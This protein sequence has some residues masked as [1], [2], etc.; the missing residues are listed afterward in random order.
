MMKKL[1]FILWVFLLACSCTTTNKKEDAYNV[2]SPL[3]VTNQ[4]RTI[5]VHTEGDYFNHIEDYLR[6]TSYVKLAPEPLLTQI[7]DIHIVDDKIF[8]WDQAHQIVCYD[9]QGNLVYRIHGIGNGPGEFSGI[10]A[11]TVNPDKAEIVVYDNLRT[12][13]LYYSMLSG[14]YLRT[15]HFSKPNPSEMV[16]FD[17][18]YFYNNRYHQNYPN[19][20]LLHYS[21]L[22]SADGLK[23]DKNYF[24]HNEA[25]ENYIFSSSMQTFYDNDAALYYCRNFDNTVYQLGKDSIKARYFIDLPDPL[26]F[27]KVEE[28]ADEWELVKSDYAFGISNVYEC[29]SLLYFCFS[30]SGYIQAALYD[31]AHDKQICCVKAMQNKAAPTIP[32]ISMINGVY[33]GRFFSVLSPD[34]IDYCVNNYAGEYPAL[35]RQYDAQSENPVIAFYEVVKPG[36]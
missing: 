26:P 36:R 34:F 16:F 18:V 19:D 5:P 22:V 17:G 12:S 35:F 27:S 20:S 1:F 10:H 21:L 2:K 14:R 28:R 4:I 23:M 11:F 9:M 25:E 33:K 13:L 24:P 8:V 32:L 30:K 29:D 31:L 6:A 15:E 7:N 3:V